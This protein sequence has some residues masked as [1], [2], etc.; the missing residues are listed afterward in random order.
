MS[1]ALSS[2]AMKKVRVNEEQLAPHREGYEVSCPGPC[3]VWLMTSEECYET[4]QSAVRRERAINA[5]AHGF[6]D[7]F[8]SKRDIQHH[9]TCIAVIIHHF[10]HF[11]KAPRY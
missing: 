9:T 5:R 2:K 10:Y 3:G 4:A 8:E 11:S 1:E 7:I 6:R